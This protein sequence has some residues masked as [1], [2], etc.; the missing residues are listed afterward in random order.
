MSTATIRI[1]RRWTDAVI[2]EGESVRDALLR[3]VARERAAGRRADLAG[4]H[5]AGAH[6]AGADL[7]RADL[8]GAHRR[9]ATLLPA[10]K[11]QGGA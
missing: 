11:A 3:F 10:P 2:C 6:L 8:T 7:A 1:T 5:L 9:E 4:A